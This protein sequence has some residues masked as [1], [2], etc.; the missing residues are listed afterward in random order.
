MRCDICVHDTEPHRTGPAGAGIGVY[1]S[2]CPECQRELLLWSG[3][4]VPG[5]DHAKSHR[6]GWNRSNVGT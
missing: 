6:G 3:A 4:V 2:A 1:C 5:A